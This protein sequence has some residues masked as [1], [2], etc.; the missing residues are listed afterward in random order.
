M[1]KF[2]QQSNLNMMIRSHGRPVAGRGYEVR[3]GHLP[4]KLARALSTKH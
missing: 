1:E 3:P 2:L 4:N